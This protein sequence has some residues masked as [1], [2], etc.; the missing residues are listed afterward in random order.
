[1]LETPLD[2]LNTPLTQNTENASAQCSTMDTNDVVYREGV[3]FL[4]ILWLA[5]D[6]W[7]NQRESLKGGKKV[8]SSRLLLSSAVTPI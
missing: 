2:A 7:E 8:R 4:Y 1:M 5:S 6:T 3:F